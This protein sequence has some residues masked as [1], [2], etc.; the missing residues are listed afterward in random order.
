MASNKKPR[1]KYVKKRDL[2][3]PIRSAI[4]R[5]TKLRPF[6]KAMLLDPIWESFEKLKKGEWKNEDFKFMADCLNV[7]QALTLPGI[8]LLPDHMDKFDAAHHALQQ[9]S[10]RRNATGKWL[11][12]GD[13]LRTIEVG[14]EFHAIQIDFVS[15]GE[16]AKATQRVDDILKGAVS[17]SPGKG[18]I[19]TVLQAD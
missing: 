11:A 6:E 2:I 13:E 19:H 3:D 8:G 1:K 5:A 16:L 10:A 12:K 18:H 15:A 17:G 7:A 14:I 4:M 9:L